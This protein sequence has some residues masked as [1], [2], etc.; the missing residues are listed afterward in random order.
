MRIGV[1]ITR[2][3]SPVRI[4]STPSVYVLSRSRIPVG[5][6]GLLEDGT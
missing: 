6:E 1:Q 5:E 2:I 3:P 4:A